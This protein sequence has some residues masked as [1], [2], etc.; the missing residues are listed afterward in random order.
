MGDTEFNYLQVQ[1][2]LVSSVI[3]LVLNVVLSSCRF[4]VC[5][6]FR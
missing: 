2:K 3:Y 6:L 1:M 4:I 5:M